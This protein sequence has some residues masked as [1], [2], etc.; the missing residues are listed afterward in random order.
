M[1]CRCLFC[2]FQYSL[3]NFA[4]SRFI[5]PPQLKSV[6]LTVVGGLYYTVSYG[7]HNVSEECNI[8]EEIE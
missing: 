1:R 6:Q 2:Y 3:E 8:E 5:H 4:A 7:L